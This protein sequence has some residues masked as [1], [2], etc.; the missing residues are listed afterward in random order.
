MILPCVGLIPNNPQKDAG[1]RTE[2]PVSDPIEKSY[3][4]E[5]IA[6]AD[7]ELEPPGTQFG[8]FKFLG[9]P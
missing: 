1:T 8:A 3:L 4:L 5:V 6:A 7:P 2:P 9:V